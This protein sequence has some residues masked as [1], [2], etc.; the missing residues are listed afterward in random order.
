MKL[1]L[2]I[3]FIMTNEIEVYAFISKAVN[4]EE[5]KRKAVEEN[6]QLQ[7]QHISFH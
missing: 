6:S 3:M 4:Y 5:E 1:F 2:F 7:T